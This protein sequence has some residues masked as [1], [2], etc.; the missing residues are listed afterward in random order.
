MAMHVA[1]PEIDGRIFAGVASFK[2]K[3]PTDFKLQFNEIKHE[4]Y[5]DGISSITQKVKSWIKLQNTSL[6]MKKPAI[7]LSTYP[8][9][10]WQIAHAVG[11]DTISSV[12]EILEYLNFIKKNENIDII[13]NLNN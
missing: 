10:K 13:N 4:T 1:L 9:K 11:L 5:K 7:I 12:Q 3:M 2:K 8:G 6:K